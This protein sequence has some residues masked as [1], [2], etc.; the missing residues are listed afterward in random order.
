MV[1]RKAKKRGLKQVQKILLVISIFVI[2]VFAVAIL[3]ASEEAQAWEDT[4]K[5]NLEESG[6]TGSFY[7]EDLE[8]QRI[9]GIIDDY[10]RHIGVWNSDDKKLV[11]LYNTWVD[12]YKDAIED[13]YLS[14]SEAY[15]ISDAIYAYADEYKITDQHLSTFKTF[16]INNERDLEDHTTVDV[17]DIKMDIDDRRIK[18]RNN[19]DYM[20]RKTEEL[21]SL[22]KE[23]EEQLSSALQMLLGLLL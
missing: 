2:V 23:R 20:K 22:Q 6:S 16:V 21:I 19:I 7:R 18:L 10:N 17:F 9:Q 8:T 12:T 11:N 4:Y 13:D 14:S 3:K 5:K 15:Q 1:K